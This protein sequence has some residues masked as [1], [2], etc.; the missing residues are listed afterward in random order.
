MATP[1]LPTLTGLNEARP[2]AE[3]GL[4]VDEDWTNYSWSAVELLFYRT[5]T[6]LGVGGIPLTISEINNAGG[7]G[8]VD[9]LEVEQGSTA[10]HVRCKAGI[11]FDRNGMLIYEA[12]Q[13]SDVLAPDDDVVRYFCVEHDYSDGVPGTYKSGYV[14][15]STDTQRSDTY[16]ATLETS[17]P[18]RDTDTKIALAKVWR[19]GA[20]QPV[21]IEDLRD[22]EA[23]LYVDYQQRAAGVLPS[24]V[25]GVA[26]T[27]GY[28]SDLM[29]GV[30]VGDRSAFLGRTSSYLRLEWT[31]LDPEP[32]YYEVHYQQLTSGSVPVDEDQRLERTLGSTAYLMMLGVSGAKARVKVRAVNEYGAGAWSSTTDI[33]LGFAAASQLVCT[34][35]LSIT[36]QKDGFSVSA[37]VVSGAVYYE[38]I[39]KEAP[40]PTDWTDGVL[41]RSDHPIFWVALESIAESAPTYHFRFRCVDYAGRISSNELTGSSSPTV[42]DGF[43]AGDRAKM[44]AFATPPVG[45]GIDME[46]V[47]SWAD[48]GIVHIGQTGARRINAD[49]SKQFSFDLTVNSADTPG[50]TEIVRFQATDDISLRGID[51]HLVEPLAPT[52]PSIDPAQDFV[53]AYSIDDVLPGGDR[54]AVGIDDQGNAGGNITQNNPWSSQFLHPAGTPNLKISKGDWVYIMVRLTTNTTV[55]FDIKGI[56]SVTFWLE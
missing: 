49:M 51:I 52:T 12:T 39:Y 3:N 7:W 55:N 8:A 23:W 15:G 41:I 24:Q 56:V 28:E 42:R 43:L 22:E 25:T 13:G 30:D 16:T 9:W 2:L 14:P 37:D 29:T 54:I 27:T 45:I 1:S 20:G 18:D 19:V 33:N 38:L 35:S 48:S 5:R 26:V 50:D 34:G 21:N 36:S 6:L 53:V 17:L 32:D 10:N 40:A 46:N 31:D 4:Q 11:A 44:D 47:A